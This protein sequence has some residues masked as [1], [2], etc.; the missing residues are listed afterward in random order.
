[1]AAVSAQGSLGASG[2]TDE[3]DGWVGKSVPRREDAPL[4]TGRG[5]FIDDLE[6]VAGLR[7]AAILRS[8]H[9]PLDPEDDSPELEAELLKAADGPFTPY[10]AVEF[11][12]IGE[13][14]IREKRGQ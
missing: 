1:M 11:Q 7:H 2:T 5:R 13:R 12:E 14:I 6:P 3:S 10:S 8:P 4:L 9:P